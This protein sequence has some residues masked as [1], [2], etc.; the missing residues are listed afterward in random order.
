MT[1]H[2]YKVDKV[3]AVLIFKDGTTEA[4]A[5]A[6]LASIEDKLERPATAHEYDSRWGG[7]VWYVP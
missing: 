5:K 4:E 1:E 6:V 3:G 7:P 2:D